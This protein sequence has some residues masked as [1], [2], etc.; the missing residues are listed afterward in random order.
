MPEKL[1][2]GMIGRNLKFSERITKQIEENKKN[3]LLKSKKLIL[4]LDLDHTLVHTES[5]IINKP[6]V[7]RYQI[8]GNYFTTKLRPHLSEFLEQL[9]SLYEMCVYTMGSH[10]YA[11]QIVHLIDPKHNYFGNRVISK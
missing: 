3:S 11:E 10:K 9:Q 6:D 8:D 5:G 4:V 7:S 2:F 1:P